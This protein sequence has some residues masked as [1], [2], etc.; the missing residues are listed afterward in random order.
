MAQEAGD[1]TVSTYLSASVR[2]E[3]DQAQAELE[4]HIVT[5]MDGRCVTCGEAEPCSGRVGATRRLLRYG[6]LPQRRPGLA[7][8]RANRSTGMGGSWFAS[9]ARQESA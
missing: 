9:P 4:R 6:R 3:L 1:R 5:G 2:V 7:G 8:V